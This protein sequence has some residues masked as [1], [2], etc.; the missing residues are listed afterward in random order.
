MFS[1]HFGA[2]IISLFNV[3]AK[4][5]ELGRIVMASGGFDPIHPGHIS[6]L[7]ESKKHGDTLVVVVNGDAFLREKKGK[8]FQ[9]LVTRCLIVSA[10]SGVDYVVP[11]EI[12]CDMTVHKALERLRPHV[13]TN[14]GDRKDKESIAE[15]STCE[16]LGI[17]IITG[18]GMEKKWSSSDFLKDWEMH[19]K[20]IERMGDASKK[21]R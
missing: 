9:D 10:I 19:Q 3:T 5:R 18:V 1:K 13:F 2:P 15:W 14:G 6:Y 20:K 4:R 11:F 16:R 8:P 7:Q 21:S 17:Q 12:E